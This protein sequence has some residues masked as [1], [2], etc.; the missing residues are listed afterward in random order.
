MISKADV[1]ERLNTLV[2][3]ELTA[4]NLHKALFSE[5]KDLKKLRRFELGKQS[6]VQFKI[7]K[8]S[9]GTTGT[10]A[11]ITVLGNPNTFRLELEEKDGQ[12]IIHSKPKINF[13]Y[14]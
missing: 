14:L 1:L 4:T 9:N 3:K 8:E 10:F 11:K 5:E 6:Y 2:G 12:M 13:S 7:H